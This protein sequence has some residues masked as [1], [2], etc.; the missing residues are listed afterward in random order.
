M[1]SLITRFKFHSY[2]YYYL[3]MHHVVDLTLNNYE[4]IMFNLHLDEF[5]IVFFH[6]K[7]QKLPV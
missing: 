7:M 3:E 4:L 2:Y 5:S 6:K 1:T